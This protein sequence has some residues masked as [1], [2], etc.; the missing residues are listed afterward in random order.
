MSLKI[1]N[2]M[3]VPENNN[4]HG[5]LILPN[6]PS[7]FKAENWYWNQI[8]DVPFLLRNILNI[9]QGGMKRLVLFEEKSGPAIEELCLKARNDS[10]VTVKLECVS[11]NRKQQKSKQ[12]YEDV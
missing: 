1:D 4:A 6:P 10:R 2:Q 9:Q 12:K 11:E 3:S 5:I 7:P 8:A